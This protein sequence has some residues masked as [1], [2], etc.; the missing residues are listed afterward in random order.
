ML[1]TGLVAVF[2]IFILLQREDLRDRL[3]RLLGSDDLQRSTTLL[4]DAAARLSR[5]FLAQLTINCCFGL[6]IAIGLW[7]IGLPSPGLWG[8]I[9]AVM[10]FV[11]FVGAFIAAAFPA[12]VGCRG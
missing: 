6:I 7:K 2:V 11:P 10:R 12:A 9:A 5:Y 1:K 4:D 3:I 8:A